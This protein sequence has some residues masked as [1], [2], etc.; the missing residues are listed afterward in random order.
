MATTDNREAPPPDHHLQESA[1]HDRGGSGEQKKKS[2]LYKDVE[3][4]LSMDNALL[5]NQEKAVHCCSDGHGGTCCNSLEETKA[6]LKDVYYNIF[7]FH[8]FPTGTLSR[9]TH[10]RTILSILLSSLVCRNI[11][12]RALSP[13]LEKS[14]A[15]APLEEL[16][17]G[18]AGAGDSDMQVTHSLRKQKVFTFLSRPQTPGELVVLFFTTSVLDRLVYFFMGAGPDHQARRP[19]DLRATFRAGV[20]IM[21]SRFSPFLQGGWHI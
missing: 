13:V 20:A 16:S 15:N 21:R 4:L 5:D 11:M 10:I 2:L 6:K 12:F 17:A 14:L 9:W 7:I 19:G 8:P 1:H 3:F 18:S